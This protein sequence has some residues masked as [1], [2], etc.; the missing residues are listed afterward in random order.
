[1][2]HD[3]LVQ[4]AYSLVISGLLHGHYLATLEEAGRAKPFFNLKTIF[5]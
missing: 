4:M 3:L 1:M 2:S 5:K